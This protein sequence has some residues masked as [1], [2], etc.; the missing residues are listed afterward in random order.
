VDLPRVAGTGDGLSG[1]AGYCSL[2]AGF[3]RILILKILQN[4][5]GVTKF[6]KLTYAFNFVLICCE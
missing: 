4:K 3:A 5:D 2:R 6:E 1:V